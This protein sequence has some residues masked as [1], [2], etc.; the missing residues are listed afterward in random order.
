MFEIGSGTNNLSYSDVSNTMSSYDVSYPTDVTS[1]NVMFYGRQA[2]G[3]VTEQILFGGHDI[4]SGKEVTVQFPGDA[5]PFYYSYATINSDDWSLIQAQTGTYSPT[6]PDYDIQF[7]F[8]SGIVRGLTSSARTGKSFLFTLTVLIGQFR[9]P[10]FYVFRTA[11][12]WA[13]YF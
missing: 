3:K 11:Y 10:F 12:F 9:A 8:E 7:S 1:G 2:K 13:R 4:E 5:F 6:I